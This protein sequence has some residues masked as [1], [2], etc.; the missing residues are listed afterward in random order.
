MHA[1]G[2]R[3]GKK[4]NLCQSKEEREREKAEDRDGRVGLSHLLL[5]EVISVPLPGLPW[6]GVTQIDL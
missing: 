2:T 1:N 6:R 5:R 3:L 4:K